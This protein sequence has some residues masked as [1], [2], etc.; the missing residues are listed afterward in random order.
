MVLCPFVYLLMKYDLSPL[1]LQATEVHSA[2]WVSISSLLSPALRTFERADIS[3]RAKPGENSLLSNLIR[4]TSGQMLFSAVSLLPSESLFS[5]IHPNAIHENSTLQ[6]LES[7]GTLHLWGLT[8]GIMADF[9][10]GL[11]SDSTEKLWSWPTFSHWDVRVAVWLL[12]RSYRQKRVHELERARSSHSNQSDT[13]LIKGADSITYATSELDQ[14]KGTA[15]GLAGAHLLD[16]YFQN[17]KKAVNVAMGLRL[18]MLAAAITI[19]ILRYRRLR[20]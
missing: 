7:R 17:M 8:L 19:L 1:D 9:L 11:D 2:H 13:V 4:L 10:Q 15:K 14:G 20:Q 12:T 6:A 18:G 5:T 3:D 16:E